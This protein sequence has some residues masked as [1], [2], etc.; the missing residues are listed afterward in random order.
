MSEERILK[1]EER[2]N[3]LEAAQEGQRVE[4]VSVNKK[5]DQILIAIAHIQENFV[6]VPTCLAKNENTRDDINGV[7]K[8]LRDLSVDFKEHVKYHW[9]KTDRFATWLTTASIGVYILGKIAK[10]F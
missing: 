7:G 3:R 1:L 5:L 2:V 9:N 10:I 8:N 6:S 4:L